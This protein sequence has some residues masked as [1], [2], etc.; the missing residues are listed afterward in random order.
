VGA[1]SGAPIEADF[2][3]LWTVRDLKVARLDMYARKAEA[4]EAAGL[5]E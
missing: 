2:W 1:A 4:L 3:F 5:R